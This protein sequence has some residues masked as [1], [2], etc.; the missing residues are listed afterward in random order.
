MPDPDLHEG[1]WL[2]RQEALG[3]L[4]RDD[5]PWLVET[6]LDEAAV[7]RIEAG[8]RARFVAAAG[9]GPSLALT[10]T[11]IDRDATRVLPRPELAAQHGGHVM[12]R[13]QDG[14]LRPEQA[15]YRVQLAIDPADARQLAIHGQHAWRGHLSI[16]GHNESPAARYLRQALAVLVRETGF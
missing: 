13:E 10:V 12:V 1:Q 14:Q 2:A 15:V 9:S 8:Q 6:W 11:A 5:D 4:V 7:A 3:M 16:D